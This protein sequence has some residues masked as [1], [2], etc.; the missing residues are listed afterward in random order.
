MT[1]KAALTFSLSGYI[2]CDAEGRLDPLPALLQAEVAALFGC[3]LELGDQTLLTR[4]FR[5]EPVLCAV[6]VSSRP[7]CGMG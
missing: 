4:H 1:L 6:W 5:L 3:R 2:L 7:V